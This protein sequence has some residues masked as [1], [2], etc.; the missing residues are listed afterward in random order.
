MFARYCSV[1]ST[2]PTTLCAKV[3]SWLPSNQRGGSGPGS[4][5]P[6]D[7]DREASSTPD[8]TFRIY[9]RQ[10]DDETLLQEI[11]RP[12]LLFFRGSL[13]FFARRT[14]VHIRTYDT[15]KKKRISHYPS[16]RPDVILRLYSKY[17]VYDYSM[18]YFVWVLSIRL[19]GA[20]PPVLEFDDRHWT[21]VFLPFTL[22]P[23]YFYFLF[24]VQMACHP[25]ARST[26]STRQR[27]KSGGGGGRWGRTH[28]LLTLVI[29]RLTTQPFRE[30]ARRMYS[31]HA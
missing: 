7:R 28:L 26:L 27:G 1:C 8:Y 5:S 11:L 31:C 16:L 12:T 14:A 13:I 10:S 2:G 9:L 22:F 4:E 6:A 3:P 19:V 18:S 21:D 25:D 15:R 20:Y 24:A 23:G 30:G 29:L 17:Q